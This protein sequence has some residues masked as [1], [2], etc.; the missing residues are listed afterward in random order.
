MKK[1]TRRPPNPSLWDLFIRETTRPEGNSV[2]I[3]R[4]IT[5]MHQQGLFRPSAEAMIRASEIISSCPG[6]RDLD[7]YFGSEGGRLVVHLRYPF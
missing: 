6:L 7:F 1:R 5:L 4:L 2:H 3:E